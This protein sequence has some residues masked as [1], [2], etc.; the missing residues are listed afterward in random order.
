MSARANS[1][2]IRRD[3]SGIAAVWTAVILLFLIGATAL[4]IDTSEFFQNARSQQRAVDLACL[5]GAAEL[6]GD[7]SMAVE[8]AADFARP[9]QPGLHLIAPGIPTTVIG[10]VST[11]RTGDFVLEVE[12]PAQYNGTADANVMRV[13]LTHEAPTRFGKVFGAESTGIRQQATCLVISGGNGGYAIFASSTTCNNT[14]DWSG[15]TTH[16]TGGVHTNNDLHVGGQTN[17]ID[18]QTTFLTTIDAPV[19]KITFI[20]DINNPTQLGGP[21]TYSDIGVDYQIEDY[22]PGGDRAVA[23]GSDY[24]FAGSDKIDMGWLTSRGLWNDTTKTL[25]DGI[26]Y[27]ED[28]IDLSA[29]E[30][31]GKVTLV[32]LDGVISLSGSE[33]HLTPWDFNDPADPDDD[34]DALLMFSN[35][36]K[37]GG[38][39]ACNTAVI[40]LAG[41]EHD[42]AGTIFAP[43][44]LIE[45]SGSNNTTLNG[46][47]IGYSVKLN[48]SQLNINYD[49]DSNAG[50]PQIKLVAGT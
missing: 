2:R 43:R 45:M 27:T 39:S 38:A 26:Y 42:W 48:G 37:S 44:G 12:T 22:Q 25:A 4:A 50:T 20:P 11:W 49:T 19:D 41:S 40:K 5:A 18:G 46:S 9:N 47:L 33:H 1:R 34:Q 13:S 28:D 15:S 3:E 7:P 14:V 32:S 21:L 30:I 10:N 35:R 31:N 23:A 16:V 6:P 17:V 24:H 36:L 8:K 29:S